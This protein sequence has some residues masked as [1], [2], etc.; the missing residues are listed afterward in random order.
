MNSQSKRLMASTLLL[1]A[2]GFSTSINASSTISLKTSSKI[3]A[4]KTAITESS[5]LKP[6]SKNSLRTITADREGHAFMMVLWSI[7]CPP[8]LKELEHF[9]ALKAQLT[10]TNIVLIST[11]SPDNRVSI[12]QV[13]VDNQLQ[14]IDSWIFS[15]S[16][17]E[18]L[19]YKIDPTWYGELP[20]TYFYESDHT[21]MAH[22]GM[23][24][25]A[26][27]QQWLEKH[28]PSISLKTTNE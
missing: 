21:R 3:T 17:P 18:R 12:E 14:A 6:F 24:T 26:K 22:S 11:D 27:L 4:S 9:Q 10:K 20:R 25:Q 13:L 1:V 15:D 16:L 2:L 28:P 5:A 8:C 19:R 7:D 23:L